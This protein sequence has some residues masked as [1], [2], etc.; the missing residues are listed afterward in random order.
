MLSHFSHVWLRNSMDCT[1]QAPLSMGLSRQEYWSELPFPPPGDLPG[2]GIE[3]GLLHC[4][5]IVDHSEPP[6]KPF[7]TFQLSCCC[8]RG[9]PFVA[10]GCVQPAA[11]HW[12][13]L[14]S[15]QLQPSLGDLQQQPRP[16]P[17]TWGLCAFLP[18][19]R[20]LTASDWVIWEIQR[21]T[22][23]VRDGN[24]WLYDSASPRS[25]AHLPSG[26]QAE[27]RLSPNL[28]LCLASLPILFYFYTVPLVSWDPF[29]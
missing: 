17:V 12:P 23:C 26:D 6:G 5:Q 8:F 1:C 9:W 21:P 20:W 14:S 18:P 19:W 25:L 13:Q 11:L 3:P 16:E 29:P 28:H 4:R 22:P 10:A 24:E 27:A 2:S 7:S 15:S